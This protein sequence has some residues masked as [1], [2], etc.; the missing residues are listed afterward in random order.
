MITLIL[1]LSIF[2]VSYFGYWT[3][4]GMGRY[5]TENPM[6][7]SHRGV[8]KTFPE[9]TIEAYKNSVSVG[10]G[11]IE[12]DVLSSLDGVIYCSHN[13]ELEKETSANGYIHQMTSVELNNIKTGIYSHPGNQKKIPRLDDVIN[14]LPKN[15][16]LNI[17]VKFSSPFDFS[18]ISLLRKKIQENEIK[19]PVLI[20]S[21]N[22]FI[23]FFARWFI[24]NVKTG[25][26]VESLNMIKWM[27]LAHPDCLHPRADLLSKN[28][29]NDCSRKNISI[30]VWTVNSDAAIKHCKKMGVE[31]IISD[32]YNIISKQIITS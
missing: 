3:A 5:Y 29:I 23:V 10:Y 24:A 22:P 28:L 8:T 18:T 27:H 6:M 7:I 16:R 17:E 32:R 13:H 30:N 20:S 14:K 4:R 21:F 26:L 19:Q 15:I 31:G 9:N 2:I 25:Y 12:L 1:V 11:G